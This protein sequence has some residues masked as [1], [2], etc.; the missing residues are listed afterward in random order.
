MP[1]MHIEQIDPARF[2]AKK[3]I[4]LSDEF[5]RD[6]YPPE[7]SHLESSD[8]L[9]QS[10]VI[11]LGGFVD[12][13]LVASVAAKLMQDDGDYAEIKRLFVIETHRGMGLSI[14][15]MNFI[16]AELERQG[17]RLLR[18]ETGVEQPEAIMLYTKLGYLKRGPF[19]QYQDD[20]L[21]VFMEKTG[22][23]GEA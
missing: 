11:F 18:L 15:I 22:I 4:A 1:D 21:S 19:G 23:D 2:D 3:I 16:E 12:G 13:Q 5:Y 20:P 8:D 10:H 17:V 14:A 6:L 9:Q 7:S